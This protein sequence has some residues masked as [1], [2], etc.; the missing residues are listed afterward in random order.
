MWLPP[1]HLQSTATCMQSQRR[2]QYMQRTLKGRRVMLDLL[3]FRHLQVR[4]T[5]A[6]IRCNHRQERC[7][8][9]VQGQLAGGRGSA[10]S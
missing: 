3:A 10:S 1:S 9:Q 6:Q 8:L 5:A 2:F 7:S 4:A